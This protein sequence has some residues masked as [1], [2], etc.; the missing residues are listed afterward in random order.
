M[1]D[2]DV[3]KDHQILFA[4]SIDNLKH[5][6]DH[7]PVPKGVPMRLRL[8]KV[9]SGPQGAAALVL[10][11]LPE[12]KAMELPTVNPAYIWRKYRYAYGISISSAPESVLSDQLLKLD[13]DHPQI[14]GSDVAN[15]GSARIWREEGCIPGEPI[16][17]ANP[18][19]DD[20]DDG[21]VLS[22]VLDGKSAKSV[23]LILDAKDMKELARAEMDSPFPIGFH[24]TF[25]PHGGL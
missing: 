22:V 14:S 7:P 6:L 20:E 19:A 15:D 12:T 24:G 13:M 4:F 8:P 16:F 1:L 10:F 2:L 18:D 9:S 21:V 5:P 25:C 3:Y 11:H 17:V 23:L